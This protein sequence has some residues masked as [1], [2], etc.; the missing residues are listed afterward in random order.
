MT[1]GPG[2]ETVVVTA[3]GMTA[4]EPEFIS[5][6]RHPAVG[7]AVVRRCFEAVDL[8][9]C[10]EATAVDGAIIGDGLDGLDAEVVARIRRRG[11]WVMAVVSDEQAAVRARMLGADSVVLLDPDHPAGAA[12]DAGASARVLAQPPESDAPEIPGRGRVVCV[13]G[14]A[15]STG[16]S[17]VALTL[18]DEAARRGFS[19]AL[20]DAD[21]TAPCLDQLAAVVSPA[22]VTWSQRQVAQGRLTRRGLLEA[23]PVT[24]S[25]VR[26][27]PGGAGDS[28]LRPDLWPTVREQLKEAVEV[29]VIDLGAFG[30]PDAEDSG[31]QRLAEAL[32]ADELV[33][34]G[35]CEP[36]GLARLMR[37]LVALSA[38]PTLDRAGPR[39]TVVVTAMPSDPASAAFVRMHVAPL[40]RTLHGSIALV[41]DDRATCLAAR[42]RGLTLAEAAPSSRVRRDLQAL[43]AHICVPAA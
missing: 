22:S 15:G 12:R 19:C 5:A 37:F 10:I 27:L 24:R 23:M 20:V 6:L 21:P 43:A 41:D 2:R 42:T 11:C 28:M 25:G 30:H 1:I 9:A 36:V 31:D 14:P 16:R 26:V 3:L 35:T 32:G 7:L 38:T 33:T 18:A 39:H 17:T 13:W 8:L 4:W 34:V 29:V 40:L